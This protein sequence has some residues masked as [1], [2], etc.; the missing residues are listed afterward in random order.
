VAS[1]PATDIEALFTRGGLL[2]AIVVVTL[3]HF[4]ASLPFMLITW[5]GHGL[6]ASGAVIWAGYTVAGAVS[7]TAAL[8][9]DA[10]QGGWW[11]AA[12]QSGVLPWGVCVLLLAGVLGNALTAPGG[13][14]GHNAFGFSSAGLFALVALWHRSLAELL[15]FFAAEACVGALAIVL[16]GETS[17]TDLEV[18]IAWCGSGVFFITIYVGS[19]AVAAVARRAAEAEDAAAM[20]RNARLAAEAVQAQRRVRYEEI[21]AT[22]APLLNGIADGS[23][24][25]AA[26][27]TRQRIT[28]AV[29]RLRRFLAESDDVPD[30]LSHEL[31]VVADAAER[32]GVAVDLIAAVGAIP[33]LGVGARRALTEPVIN[34]LGAATARAR[35]TVVASDAE[36]SVAIVADAGTPVLDVAAA[37]R[38]AVQVE[39][40]QGGDRLWAQAKWTAPSASLS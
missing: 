18:Y 25:L 23:L 21:R 15:G 6:V 29:T 38:A 27:G 36:V 31:R 17:R 37:A 33:L 1:R 24:D 32:R 3:W 8:R 12:W 39:W 40:D 35:I 19:R 9:A 14:F 26:P 34:V 30:P 28:V 13:L 7:A 22:V 11:R 10:R 16:L 5:S 4:A 2:V 20:T